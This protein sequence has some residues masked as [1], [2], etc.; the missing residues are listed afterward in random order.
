MV[1]DADRKESTAR[2]VGAAA[3]ALARCLR[4]GGGK[5]EIARLPLL[6]GASETGLDDISVAGGPEALDRALADVGPRPVLPYLRPADRNVPAGEWLGN[7]CPLPSPEEAPLVI[8]QA[9]MGCGK[10]SA[11]R[12]AL[13]PLLLDGVRLLLPSHRRALGQA[14]AEQVGIPWEATPSSDERLQ[15]VSGCLDSWCPESRLQIT[16]EAGRGGDRSG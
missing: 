1:F 11:I 2:K 15:G 6:P 3:G 7:A 10:S 4:A 8:L 5:P 12:E 16:G 14:L 9:P 13:S